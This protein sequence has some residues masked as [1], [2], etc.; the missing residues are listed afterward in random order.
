MD[1]P[2][3]DDADELPPFRWNWQA[4]FMVGFT[5]VALAIPLLGVVWSLRGVMEPPA[6]KPPTEQREAAENP[7]LRAA[8]EKASDPLRVAPLPDDR[9]SLTIPSATAAAREESVRKLKEIVAGRGGSIVEM[10]AGHRFLVTGPA[11]TF[12]AV[13]QALQPDKPAPDGGAGD[14][15]FEV[16]FP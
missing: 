14:G 1:E 11:G 12:G 7:G 5:I 8:L 13:S 10:E 6:P 3:E 2:K 9:A 4:V 16:R 15:L